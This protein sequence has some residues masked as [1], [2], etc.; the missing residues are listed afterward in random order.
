MGSG[1]AHRASLDYSGGPS[2]TGSAVE[3]DQLADELGQL[4]PQAVA[5]HRQRQVGFQISGDRPGV[6]VVALELERHDAIA[7]D[8]PLY[9]IRELNLPPGP[10]LEVSQLVEDGGVEHV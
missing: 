1:Q 9:R 10:G 2:A 7:A 3:V 6:V 8:R 5:F 4:V